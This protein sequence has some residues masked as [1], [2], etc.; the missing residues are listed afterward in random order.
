[1]LGSIELRWSHRTA[2]AY[3]AALGNSLI[4]SQYCRV[5]TQLTDAKTKKQKNN[6]KQPGLQRL[7]FEDR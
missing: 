7:L 4:S 2:S 6:K 3:S 1:M 5:L